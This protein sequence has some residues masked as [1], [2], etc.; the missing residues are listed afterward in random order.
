MPVSKA[1]VDYRHSGSINLKSSNHSSSCRH[2]YWTGNFVE[3]LQNK[4]CLRDFRCGM[5]TLRNCD[6]SFHSRILTLKAWS[7]HSQSLT[8][9]AMILLYVSVMIL[10]FP[11]RCL[12]RLFRWPVTTTRNGSQLPVLYHS[13]LQNV[14]LFVLCIVWSHSTNWKT[15]FKEASLV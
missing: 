15:K 9:K 3:Y 11:C 2:K 7:F 14:C 8:L 4:L 6:W 10:S 1:K 13:I 5:K 12:L